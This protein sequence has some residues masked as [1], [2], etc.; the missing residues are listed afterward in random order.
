MMVRM[1]RQQGRG[2]GR[3][4]MAGVWL[5]LVLG[6][7]PRT[8]A[9]SDPTP[10]KGASADKGPGGAQPA[11]EDPLAGWEKPRVALFLTGRQYGYIEPCGCTGLAN[12]KG[13]LARKYSLLENLRNE[14][15]WTVVPLDVGNQV[16][17]FGPQAEIQFRTTIDAL[18]KMRYEAVGLGPDDLRLSPDELL[19]VVLDQPKGAPFVCA[20]MNLLGVLEHRY[21]IVEQGGIRIGITAILGKSFAADV[22]ASEIEKQEVDAALVPVDAQ[23]RKEKCHVNVLLAHASDEES[24]DLA[25]RYPNFQ[26]IVTSAGAGEPAHE[27]QPVP[28]ARGKMIQ[29]GTKG[30]FV[31]VVGIYGQ[32]PNQLKVRYARVPLDARYPDAAAMLDSLAEYQ[33]QL[34]SQGLSK[35][36][37]EPVPHPTGRKFVGSQACAECHAAEYEK[38]EQTPHAKAT[39]SLHD[40]RERSHVP[41]H[42]DPECL[43][44]HVT[45]WNPQ[46]FFP[47]MTGYRDYE[48]SRAL[49]GNGCENCHGPGDQH[50]AAESGA[51]SVDQSRMASLR[52]QM[53]AELKAE[54]CMSCHDLDNS[55]DFHEPGAFERYWQEIAH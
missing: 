8:N 48:R 38:W 53:R 39:H 43:S 41:R 33:L 54:K 19:S 52:Q 21:R 35:L 51:T 17:R 6:S 25:R 20:N 28:E 45:G 32:H 50:V 49:H 47:Y 23:L 12:Q 30:M 44:C 2:P 4:L 27:M 34:K 7:V 55:P 11:V 26:L 18:R 3:V 36:G 37:L 31:G 42:H 5:G 13:G 10:P 15:N 9:A 29:V 16:R 22:H 24:R 40:P 46:E 1:I 14:R